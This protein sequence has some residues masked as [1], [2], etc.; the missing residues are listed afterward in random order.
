MGVI[1]LP[2]LHAV[3]EVIYIYIFFFFFEKIPV[4]KE[5]KE[6]KKTASSYSR[7]ERGDQ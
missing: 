2:G 7:C 5:L 6:K 4:Q 1:A 3:G